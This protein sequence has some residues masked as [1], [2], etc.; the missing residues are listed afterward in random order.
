[1]ETEDGRRPILPDSTKKT[2]ARG[3]LITTLGYGLWPFLVLLSEIVET[4]ILADFCYY[5]VNSLVG[6]HLVLRLPP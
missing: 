2:Y 4:F 3:R 5:Y 6:G 1:M